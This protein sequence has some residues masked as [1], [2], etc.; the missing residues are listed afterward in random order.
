MKE[1]SLVYRIE[2]SPNP[3]APVF[4]LVHGRAGTVDVMWMF[5]RSLPEDATVISVQAPIADSGDIGFGV[6]H[7]F[8]WW[9]VEPLENITRATIQAGVD[10]LH[11][12]INEVLAEYNLQGQK[13]NAL[14]FSQGAAAL[15]C[16]IQQVPQLF[17]KVAMLAG[18]VVTNM[19]GNNSTASV[20]SDNK[21]EVLIAHGTKDTVVPLS[22]AQQGKQY[23]E[24]DLGLSVTLVTDDV[25]HKVGTMG[26]KSVK[27][28]FR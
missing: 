10:T 11:T 23:L 6:Q 21:V 25:G 1:L 17:Q 9:Q 5:R 19:K 22:R 12:F 27:D 18:F 16:L 15:S 26:M 8:S 3:S 20:P 7:G 4:L 14:G 24:Q 13:I 28:F 2:Q